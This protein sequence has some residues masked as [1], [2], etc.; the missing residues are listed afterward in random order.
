MILNYFLTPDVYR[1]MDN[2]AQLFVDRFLQFHVET[3]VTSRCAIGMVG[4]LLQSGQF[5]CGKFKFIY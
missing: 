2:D 4:S 5:L 3:G 1:K